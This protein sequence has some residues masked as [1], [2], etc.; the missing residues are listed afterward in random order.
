MATPKKAAATE[1]A[2]AT[3]AVPAKKAAVK[4][5]AAFFIAGF[6]FANMFELNNQL[7]FCKST[8]VQSKKNLCNRIFLLHRARRNAFLVSNQGEYLALKI[9]RK[10]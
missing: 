6:G 8:G 9:L 2:A 5:T 7:V 4:I 10:A 1:K 3:K